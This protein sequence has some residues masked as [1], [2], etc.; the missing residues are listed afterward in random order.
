MA[1]RPR[2]GGRTGTTRRT[3]RGRRGAAGGVISTAPATASSRI[4]TARVYNACVDR[5][6]GSPSPE[7]RS[8]VRILVTGG[9]G[10]IGSNFVRRTLEDAYPGLEGADVVVYDALTYSGNLAN[11]APVA[12]NAALH[13]RA[14]RHPRQRPARP[15]PARRRRVV[16][17]AAEIH[18]DRSVRR[19]RALRRH[20][21][22]RHPAA[23][24]REPGRR[25]PALRARQH[26]RGVRLDRRGLVGRDAAARA[27]LAVLG[28]QGRAATCSRAATTARTA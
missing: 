14:R 26:R 27:Q 20:Q 5:L 22:G 8:R 3:R 4:C 15:Q 9:A 25:H 24:R 21:R 18:V 28:E 2:R 19:L 10:F 17:F 6:P 11:L 12:D 7:R 1:D 23:A 13:V 16:H